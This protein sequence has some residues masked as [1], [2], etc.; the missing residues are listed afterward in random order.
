[1]IS[2][3]CSAC[4]HLL[5]VSFAGSAWFHLLVVSFAGSAWFGGRVEDYRCFL[6]TL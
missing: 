3:A 4:F 1:M 5:V 6:V 2:F